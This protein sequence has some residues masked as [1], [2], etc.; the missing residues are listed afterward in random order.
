MA[1]LSLV[2]F[3]QRLSR[4]RGGAIPARPRLQVEA[5]E[6]RALPDAGTSVGGALSASLGGASTTPGGAAA[7]TAARDEAFVGKLYS[8]LLHRRPADGELAAWKAAL[9]GGASPGQVAAAFTAGPEYQA[10]QV[11]ALYR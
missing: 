7:G 2:R 8:D 1:P 3:W 10:D 6:H 11:R 9:A 5:L 4:R